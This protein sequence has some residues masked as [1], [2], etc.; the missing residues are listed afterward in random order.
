MA[1][2]GIVG[3]VRI[4]LVKLESILLNISVSIGIEATTAAVIAIRP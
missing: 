4:G 2:S 1:R 3:N